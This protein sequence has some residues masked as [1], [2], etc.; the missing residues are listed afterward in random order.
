MSNVSISITCNYKMVHIVSNN[1]TCNY[2]LN[3]TLTPAAHTNSDIYRQEMTS[4]EMNYTWCTG[5]LTYNLASNQMQRASFDGFFSSPSNSYAM[6]SKAVEALHS[7]NMRNHCMSS[8]R[9]WLHWRSIWLLLL[10]LSICSIYIIVNYY[11]YE[12]HLPFSVTCYTTHEM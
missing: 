8:E 3:G 9:C 2:I 10:L 1:C 4:S 12:M 11:K 7:C 6:T 5:I